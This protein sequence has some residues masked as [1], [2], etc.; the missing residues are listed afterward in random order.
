MHNV[1]SGSLPTHQY[2]CVDG[3]F[4]GLKRWEPAVWFGL[5]AHPARAWGCTV[6]LKSG[7]VYRNLPPN[8]IAWALPKPGQSYVKAWSL[9]HAQLWNCYGA[10]FSLHEYDYLS[11]LG[12]CVRVCGEDIKG[13][14]LFTAIPLKDAYT[15]QPEQDKEFMFIKT[16]NGRL[17]I[18]PTNRVKFI[19][20]S[21]TVDT[22]W[23]KLTVSN[24]VYNCEGE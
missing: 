18:Q 24:R 8:A 19:D 21:F 9:K 12:V 5:H 14:Y 4:I 7:A 2:V 17:T 11:G 15:A 6:M 23:P 13:E 10:E 1:G 20:P 16:E 22:G 3:S